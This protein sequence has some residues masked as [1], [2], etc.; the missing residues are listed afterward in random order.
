MRL[1]DGQ[2]V[3]GVRVDWFDVS[4]LSNCTVKNYTV[5]G[6]DA[7]YSINC[8]FQNITAKGWI[9]AKHSN[10]LRTYNVDVK[11]YIFIDEELFKLI[12]LTNLNM[13]TQTRLHRSFKKLCL[14]KKKNVMVQIDGVYFGWD[15]AKK[16][17]LK[18]K[19]YTKQ[20]LLDCDEEKMRVI[21]DR[22]GDHFVEIAEHNLTI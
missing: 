14:R 11:E 19:E 21:A 13:E 16:L 1:K 3:D 22:L 5:E 4:R 18:P 7:E 2:T 9:D 15:E 12:N 8:T 10:N 17:L 20:D 6:F